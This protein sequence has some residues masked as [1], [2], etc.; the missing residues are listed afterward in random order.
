ML[1]PVAPARTSPWYGLAARFNIVDVL[2]ADVAQ[3]LERFLAKEEVA[4]SRP[5]IRSD[6]QRDA[7]NV[8]S[9]SYGSAMPAQRSSLHRAVEPSAWT[10]RT[11]RVPVGA[12]AST[13]ADRRGD[14]RRA[15][16]GPIKRWW[17]NGSRAWPRTACRKA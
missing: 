4:G 9:S 7:Q 8:G 1:M 14:S 3:G 12:A 13:S 15:G 5:A 16:G 17:R 10:S 11:S 6:W 2:H